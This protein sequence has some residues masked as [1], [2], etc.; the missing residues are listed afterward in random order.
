MQMQWVLTP[1]GH[2]IVAGLLVAALVA[3]ALVVVLW[4]GRRVKRLDARVAQLTAALALLTDTA[5]AGFQ[6]LLRQTTPAVDKRPAA[7]SPRAA[8]RRRIRTAA[9]RGRPVEQIAAAEQ[10]SEGEVRLMLQMSGGSNEP[11]SHAE[12]R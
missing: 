8:T 3:Q 10:L 9:K 7:P 1:E 11:A 5:E 12:M 2:W 6:D 4:Q